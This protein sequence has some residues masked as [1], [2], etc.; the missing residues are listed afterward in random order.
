MSSGGQLSSL[1]KNDDD[2]IGVDAS[3]VD[4]FVVS[5]GVVVKTSIFGIFVASSDE[6]VLAISIV[7]VFAGDDATL[8]MVTTFIG[9][10]CDVA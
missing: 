3:I 4:S 7:D 10:G 6:E 9:F 5:V 2:K 8:V 1:G